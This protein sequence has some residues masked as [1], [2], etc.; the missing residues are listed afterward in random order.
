MRTLYFSIIILLFALNSSAQTFDLPPAVPGKCYAKCFYPT[1]F[2]A[3]EK[4]YRVYIGE[5]KVATLDSIIF[6]NSDEYG[7]ISFEYN[8]T[9]IVSGILKISDKYS[10]DYILDESSTAFPFKIDTFKV[11]QRVNEPIQDWHEVLC[12]NKTTK[13][14]LFNLQEKLWE[15]GYYK[16]DKTRKLDSKTK[17]ALINFQKDN[18]LPYGQLNIESLKALGIRYSH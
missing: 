6:F 7:K 11:I 13:K 3:S 2:I 15:L 8:D 9:S 10:V 5:S 1:K 12:E 4:A 14:L 17:S 16:G 18:N